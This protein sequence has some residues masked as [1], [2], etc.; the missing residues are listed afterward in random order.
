MTQPGIDNGP[1]LFFDG[2][3]NLC[4]SAVQFII[5]HDRQGK[6]RFAALQSDAG[7]QAQQAIKAQMG[8]VPDSLILF[9]KGRYYVQSAAALKAAGYLDGGWYMLKALFVFPAFIRNAV[10]GLIAAK[11]YKWFGKR[12]SCMMPTRDLQRRFVG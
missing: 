5:R 4:N 9:D 10:Y 7:Q 6:V 11:R 12:D 2:V 8:T 3:C 1:I